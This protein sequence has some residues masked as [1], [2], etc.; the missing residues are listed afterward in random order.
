MNSKLVINNH[1][2]TQLI[3]FALMTSEILIYLCICAIDALCLHT[4]L[5]I[6]I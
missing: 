4:M 1:A 3:F 6:V 2:N 5:Y